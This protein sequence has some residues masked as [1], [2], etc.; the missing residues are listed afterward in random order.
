[1]GYYT[2]ITGDL[3]I[4]PAIDEAKF[5]DFA[6]RN[7]D[8]GYFSFALRQGDEDVQLVNGVITVVGKTPD[9]TEVGL[10]FDESIKA[11]D[12]RDAVTLLVGRAKDLG[13]RVDGAFYGDGEESD[14]FWRIGVDNN[15]ISSEGGEIVYPSERYEDVAAIGRHPRAHGHVVPRPDR[16]RAACN[17]LVNLPHCPKC[18][19][20]YESLSRILWKT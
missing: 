10:N 17:G 11:Y 13:H 12:F 7:A 2:Y 18:I 1:M 14:D 4:T 5:K 8:E 19:D 15:V 16:R 3:T 9:V 6:D 20:E